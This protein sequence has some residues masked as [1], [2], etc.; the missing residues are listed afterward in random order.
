MISATLLFTRMGKGGEYDDKLIIRPY[1]GSREIFQVTYRTPDVSLDRKFLTSFSGV[2]SY[3]EDILTSMRHDMDP[4]E[5][6]QV[7]T[8]IHPV[9]FY[10]VSD[11]DESNIRD[12]IVNMVRDSMRFDVTS[13]PR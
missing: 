10:H 5:Y 2:L 9:I 8:N 1:C 12:L 6:I 3:V 13:F 11:M 7:L 4:F